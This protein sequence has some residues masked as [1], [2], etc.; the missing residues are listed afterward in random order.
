MID[1]DSYFR[2][3]YSF[4]T[5]K[6]NKAQIARSLDVAESTVRYWLK[7]DS[8][9]K[10]TYKKR[11]SKLDAYKKQID[12]LLEQ[13][14]DYSAVQIMQF[15]NPNGYTGSISTLKSH[16]QKVRP[17]VKRT[18]LK[19][20]FLPGDC[21]QVDWGC[22]GFIMVGNKK[23]RVSFFVIVDTYTR[24]LYVKFT[25]SERQDAWNECHRDAFEYFGGV[26]R[27]VMVDN[28]KTAVLK[29]SKYQATIYNPS[30]MDLAR[31]YNFQIVACNVREPQE[32]GIVE[33]CVSYVRKSFITGRNLQPF[34]QLNIDVRH[35]LDSVANTRI[36]ATTNKRPID[37]H[38]DANLQKAPVH[39]YDCSLW[40]ETVIDKQHR[41]RYDSNTYTAPAEYAFVKAKLQITYEKIRI[42]AKG[43]LIAD[44]KRCYERKRDIEDQ[45][46]LHHL[47]EGKKKA[48]EQKMTAWFLRICP[49]SEHFYEVLK[50][51][52][53]HLIRQLS[54]LFALGQIYSDKDIALAIQ[55][56]IKYQAYNAEYIL[57][58]LEAKAHILPSPGPLH[59]SHKVDDLNMTL[60]EP[61]LDRYKDK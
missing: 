51:R 3:H 42:W 45:Q 9:T 22:A 24:M 29:N 2:I 52:S 38:P 35:W 53:T 55:D 41:I 31:H 58:I 61:N 34:E 39:P 47:L 18:F 17:S 56:A 11:A 6:M 7:R 36:H 27:R 10:K 19:L 33:R 25:L 15:L 54:K 20:N 30:Y 59:I 40:L 60:P 57:N 16:L 28:C 50:E 37:M 44:H 26:P 1:Y 8:Y 46:H 14:P 48:K 13:C 23:R 32:K 49:E 4:H 43:R 21:M 12:Q 5:L